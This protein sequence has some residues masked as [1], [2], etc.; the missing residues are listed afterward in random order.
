MF[1]EIFPVFCVGCDSF[2]EFLCK[3]CAHS[4]KLTTT[5]SRDGFVFSSGFAYEG[6]MAK[7][8]SKFKDK[9]QFGYGRV[10]AKRLQ[11]AL[12][13]ESNLPVLVPPSTKKAFRKRGFDP[14]YELAKQTGLNVSNKLRRN[15]QTLD[16]QN[17]DFLQ[18]QK[19]QDNAF[20][21]LT[22]GK[23]ML[24]DDVITTG[25]TIREMIRAVEASGGEI[26]GVMALCSTSTKGAN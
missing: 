18:R 20:Q 9:H 4:V 14:S 5:Q 13:I 1:S 6:V 26:A 22:P 12:L 8:L 24:F 16:Q 23:Y 2:N 21:L 10:I 25:A 19:N 15:K 17:L 7:A 11:D 3:E